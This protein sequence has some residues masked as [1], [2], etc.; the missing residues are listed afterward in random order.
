MKKRQSKR[1]RIEQLEAE[2][3]E[4]NR[5]ITIL[6]DQIAAYAHKF[7][8]MQK[9]ANSIPEGCEPG[10]YCR[11]CEFSAVYHMY[12]PNTRQIEWVHLCNKA[13]SCK[14][15]VQRHTED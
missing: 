15:F 10:E 3:R 4:K 1:A 13:G 5:K 8:A 11:A 12:D 6:E 7:E 9:V 14:N 2:L